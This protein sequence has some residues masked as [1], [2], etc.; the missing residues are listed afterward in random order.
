MNIKQLIIAW[1]TGLAISAVLFLTPKIATWKGDLIILA[2]DN[3]YSAPLVNWSLVIS[4]SLIILII[5][6]LL[7]YSLKN[8]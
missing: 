6:S 8:K 1:I 5:G 4:L 2:K 7:I 3:T